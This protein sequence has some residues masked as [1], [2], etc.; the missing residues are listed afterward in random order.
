MGD[1]GRD[2]E[3]KLSVAWRGLGAGGGVCRGIG[4]RVE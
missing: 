4:E 2:S 1:D 3:E